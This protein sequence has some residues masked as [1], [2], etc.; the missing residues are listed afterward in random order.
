[1][2]LVADGQ[3]K[4]HMF[5]SA[6]QQRFDS[7]LPAELEHG[8]ETVLFLRISATNTFA[9]PRYAF[10]RT[11]WPSKGLGEAP[12]MQW[13]LEGKTGLAS[14]ESGRIFAVSKLD[15][16]PLEQ[17]EV[18]ILLQPGETTTLEICLPHCPVSRERAEQ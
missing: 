9:S 11:I 12:A 2:F 5:T 17:E 7:L 1:D 13:Q 10:L 3:A 18:V 6:Q 14:Y 16:V 15:G 4:Q 8:E